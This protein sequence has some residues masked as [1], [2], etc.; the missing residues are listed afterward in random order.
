MMQQDVPATRLQR[1]LGWIDHRTGLNLVLKVSLDEPIPGGARWA[2]IFGS[3]LLFIF[4]SQMITGICLA[5]YY[6][7]SAQ[8][9]HV[10]VAYITKQVAAGAFL[11]SLHYYGSSAMVIVL[12]LH[13]LQTF[14]YGAYKGRRELLWLSGSVLAMLVLGMAFTGYLLPWDQKAYFATAVGTNIVS[15]VP[16]VGPWMTRLLRGG[17]TMG[18]LTLSRFYVA[19]LFLIPGCIFAFIALHIYLFRKAGAA[20][21]IE[22][23]PIEPQLPPESF[24]PRQVL[25]DLAFSMVLVTVLGLLAHFVPVGLGPRANPAAASYLPRPEWYYLPMFEWLK[26][27]EGPGALFGIV[28]APAFLALLFFLLPF[29]DRSLERRPWRRPVPLLA[30]SIVLLGMVYLGFRSHYQD[31]HDPAVRNQLAI[32]AEQEKAYTESPFQPFMQMPGA[33]NLIEPASVNPMVAHGKALFQQNGCSSC[34]GPE[35]GGAIGPSLVGIG[36]KF[37]PDALVALLQN[38][39]AAMRARGMPTPD[40]SVSDLKDLVSY[41]DA[42]GTP[43]ANVPAQMSASPTPMLVK[44][45][46]AHPES[47]PAAQEISSSSPAAALV[48]AVAIPATADT[49]SKSAMLQEGRQIFQTHAC[50]ACHGPTGQGTARAPALAGWASTVPASLI[51]MK[52]TQ[53]TAAMRA[54]GMIQVQL[55]PDQLDAL[56]AYLKSLPAAKRGEAKTRTASM[57]QA[58]SAAPMQQGGMP[59]SQ[60]S[61]STTASSVGASN[62]PNGHDVYVQHACVAC[63]GVTGQGN[64]IAPAL[65]GISKQLS[66][67]QFNSLIHQPTAAMRAKGMPPATVTEAETKALWAYIQTLPTPNANQP[68]AEVPPPSV[69]S[70]G[71][72]PAPSAAPATQVAPTGPV[73]AGE[74]IFHARGC[75]ACH[76][77]NGVGTP[78]AVSLIG[79]TK[80]YSRAQITSLVHQ[81]NAKMRAGGMPA[82]T[83]ND[84]QMD[85]L[86]AYL[87]SLKKTTG[88]AAGAAAPVH[89]HPVVQHKLTAEEQT[90]KHLYFE[91]RCSTCHGD[92]GMEGTAAAPSLTSTASELPPDMIRKLLEHPSGQMQSHGMPSVNLNSKDLN[93]LIAY[94][95]S[96]R[97]NR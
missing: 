43:A 29:L 91:N 59:S 80:K 52:V 38:P 82:F 17:D 3:G 57:E 33:I 51:K 13:F 58:A 35:G 66:E 5:I 56:V 47:T 67:A 21:P 42:L 77:V 81:P 85:A 31:M 89:A 2:Y 97:Y 73:S 71:A 11:R 45:G 41:L 54:K 19:H 18:T 39:N 83:F 7:P 88:N 44:T 25:M 12:V 95:R 64:G 37:N 4:I 28:I 72:T 84:S 63:H 93:A 50:F 30:V 1:L 69:A 94:I 26:F 76:G 53:P 96:L 27:W 74:Q 68:S 14:L 23:N 87:A 55:P 16:L 46:G 86:F 36:S 6:V 90:G 62:T 34:H 15:Q 65:A 79:V 8:N 48:P 24:Y 92:G 61:A 75:I 40:L 22:E 70:S 49:T 78:L 20:G 10:S 60:P 32:Q 9:A